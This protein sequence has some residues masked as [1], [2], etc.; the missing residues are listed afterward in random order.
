[1]VNRED[2]EIVAIHYMQGRKETEVIIKG[3]TAS[4]IAQTVIALNLVSRLDHVAYLGAELK[5]AEIALKTGRS[6]LQDYPLFD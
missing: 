6:Y 3:K 1:M 2:Q 5:K 4:E